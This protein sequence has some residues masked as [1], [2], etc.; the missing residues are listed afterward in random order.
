MKTLFDEIDNTSYK[1]VT[2]SEYNKAVKDYSNAMFDLFDSDG[3]YASNN[4]G[5]HLMWLGAWTS[6]FI[7]REVVDYS[8]ENNIPLNVAFIDV[9]K[10]TSKGYGAESLEK[11]KILIANEKDLNLY[12]CNKCKKPSMC[13]KPTKYE[14]CPCGLELVTLRSN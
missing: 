3:N 10:S 5:M 14:N 12:W 2:I 4:I 7:A 9:L 1:G 11:I 6:K 13:T 8:I